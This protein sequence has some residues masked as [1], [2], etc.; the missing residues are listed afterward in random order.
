VV[1]A[2]GLGLYPADRAMG[3]ELLPFDNEASSSDTAFQILSA[4]G[5]RNCGDSKVVSRIRQV[6]IYAHVS[7]S[8]HVVAD[9]QRGDFDQT[10][11][12]SRY[13]VGERFVLAPD[14]GYYSHWVC[15]L[16]PLAFQPLHSANR[17]DAGCRGAGYNRVDVANGLSDH[18]WTIKE[19]IERAA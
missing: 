2:V 7:E 5:R 3:A 19:Q 11:S 4:F 12:R 6:R 13:R 9:N 14:A 18:V 16:A 15:A 10:N 1:G 17:H 8:G